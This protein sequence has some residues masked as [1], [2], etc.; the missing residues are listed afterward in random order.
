MMSRRFNATIEHRTQGDTE[1]PIIRLT[2]SEYEFE[3]TSRGINAFAQSNVCIA[4]GV[5]EADPHRECTPCTRSDAHL[6]EQNEA[7]LISRTGDVRRRV[8]GEVSGHAVEDAA[9]VVWLRREQ[10][11]LASADDEIGR[12]LGVGH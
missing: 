3:S 5:F 1:E 9:E 4:G 11:V 10:E 6:R 8:L 2:V 12:D 7:H